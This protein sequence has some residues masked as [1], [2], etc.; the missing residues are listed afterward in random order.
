M[1]PLSFGSKTLTWVT[2]AVHMIDGRGASSNL[3]STSQNIAATFVNVFVNA[4]FRLLQ[5][6]RLRSILSPTPSLGSLIMGT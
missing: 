6:M 3:D 1:L 5:Y 4:G 2:D